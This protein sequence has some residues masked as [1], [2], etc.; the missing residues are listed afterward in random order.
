MDSSALLSAMP[1][2]TDVDDPTAGMEVVEIDV[3]TD[4][5]VAGMLV[6]L[7]STALNDMPHGGMPH[8]G[9][10]GGMGMGQM[11]HGALSDGSCVEGHG[12]ARALHTLGAA[13]LSIPGS[14]QGLPG[15]CPA[16]LAGVEG[17]GA[18]ISVFP[19]TSVSS[20]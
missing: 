5:F 15:P 9:P 13:F 16:H 19:P 7:L 17:T 12:S 20:F 3:D 6:G 10:H 4:S 18:Y 1:F 14:G 2:K 8:G 11:V